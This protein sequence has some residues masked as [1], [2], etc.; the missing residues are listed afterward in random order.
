[1]GGDAEREA[2]CVDGE[3]CRGGEERGYASASEYL[4]L[5][6]DARLSKADVQALSW[7]GKSGGWSEATLA[8]DGDAGRGKMVFE[9][10]CVGCHA[11]DADREGP[12]LAGVFGRKA[13][14][15]PGFTYS[16]GLKSLGL[17]W[18]D[19]TLEK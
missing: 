12:R 15:V 19:T 10:R 6:W 14:S 13:G 7:L 8:G 17:T 18:N 9:K 5:H 1:M 11:L 2:G 3:D 16:A 4:A